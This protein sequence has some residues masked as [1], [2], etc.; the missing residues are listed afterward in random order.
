MMM[1]LFKFCPHSVLSSYLFTGGRRHFFFFFLFL[2]STFLVTFHSGQVQ[3]DRLGVDLSTW[4]C[5]VQLRKV[6][7]ALK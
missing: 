5:V 1:F 4:P 2:F 7:V 6:C 3:R